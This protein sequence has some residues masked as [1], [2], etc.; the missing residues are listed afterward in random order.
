MNPTM[1]RT[2]QLNTVAG[3]VMS[4]LF[5]SVIVRFGQPIAV[6]RY[7]D[8]ADD[9]GVLRQIIGEVMFEIRELSS[10]DYVNTY[11]DQDRSVGPTVRALPGEEPATVRRSSVEVLGPGRSSREEPWLGHGA[12]AGPVSRNV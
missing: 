4:P 8:R 3:V 9:R 10:Q 7:L 2:G 1:P 12:L 11:A 5:R 6:R